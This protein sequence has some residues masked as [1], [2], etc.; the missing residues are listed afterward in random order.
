MGVRPGDGGVPD[1]YFLAWKNQYYDP[2]KQTHYIAYHDF[3]S[4]EA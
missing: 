3:V 4:P 1:S 2:L